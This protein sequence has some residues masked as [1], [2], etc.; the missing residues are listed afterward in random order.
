MIRIA[1]FFLWSVAAVGAQWTPGQTLTRTEICE[2]S[3]SSY[4]EWYYSGTSCE[5]VEDAN[6]PDLITIECVSDEFYCC[7]VTNVCSADHDITTLRVL[8]YTADDEGWPLLEDVFLKICKYQPPSVTGDGKDDIPSV[9]VCHS[10]DWVTVDGVAQHESCK[11]DINGQE[12]AS[13][14]IC[15]PADK[16][17]GYDCTN[18]QGIEKIPTSMLGPGPQTECFFNMVADCDVNHTLADVPTSV[19]VAEAAPAGQLGKSGASSYNTV[20]GQALFLVLYLVA[21]TIAV[22]W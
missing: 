8:D 16:T 15:N 2:G 14:F 5:C 19:N 13:C 17:T 9:K 12:C 21:G 10:M 3:A 20:G 7:P 4:P 18:I 6:D 11:I 1:K 22:L